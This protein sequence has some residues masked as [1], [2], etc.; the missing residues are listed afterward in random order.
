MTG[1]A[2]LQ[3][4]PANTVRHRHNRQIADAEAVVLAKRVG[5]LGS[6]Y[7]ESFSAMSDLVKFTESKDLLCLTGVGLVVAAMCVTS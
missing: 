4:F 5:K 2:P 6:D 3:A 1:V 7:R